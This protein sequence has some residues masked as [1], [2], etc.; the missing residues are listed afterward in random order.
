MLRVSQAF[1]GCTS[2]YYTCSEEL[3]SGSCTRT[4]SNIRYMLSR[5]RSKKTIK[6]IGY[7]QIDFIAQSSSSSK[8]ED[9]CI[10]ASGTE[11]S[12]GDGHSHSTYHSISESKSKHCARSWSRTGTLVDR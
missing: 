10:S 6:L 2:R 11:F 12:Y 1:I 9:R 5:S 8:E 7:I 3:G 4:V